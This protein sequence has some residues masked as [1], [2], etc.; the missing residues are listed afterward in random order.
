MFKRNLWKITL[1][2]FIGAWAISSILPLKD[3]P[4]NDYIQA[5]VG[6]ET[7]EFEALMLQASERAASGESPSVFVALKR[8]G[9][10]QRI[11]LAKFFPEVRLEESLK[12]VEK[13]NAI[14]LDYLL[15][16]SKGRLQLG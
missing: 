5:S 14:L 1:T 3:T 8:I 16:E 15:Q 13:R 12:N 11:D 4:F 10:E 2:A 7:T 9:Q 6:A